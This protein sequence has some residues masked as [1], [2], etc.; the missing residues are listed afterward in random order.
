MF[1]SDA[2]VV[3]VLGNTSLHVANKALYD[4]IRHTVPYGTIPVM[5]DN[6]YCTV[7]CVLLYLLVRNGTVRYRTVSAAPYG[8]LPHHF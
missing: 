6:D 1:L 3:P 2:G 5:H 4:T 8:T 7:P